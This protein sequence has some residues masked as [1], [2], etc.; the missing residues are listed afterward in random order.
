MMDIKVSSHQELLL[1]VGKVKKLVVDLEME[2]QRRCVAEDDNQLLHR[3]FEYADQA[4]E[5]LQFYFP[6]LEA[7]LDESV[8]QKLV[9]ALGHIESI[10]RAIEEVLEGRHRMK[11]LCAPPEETES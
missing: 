11:Q 2:L 7:V 9:S 1:S 3:L 8:M 6:Q 5:D 4:A 10:R